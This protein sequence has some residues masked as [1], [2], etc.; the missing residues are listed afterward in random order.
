MI[1]AAPNDE[2][3]SLGPWRPA[4]RAGSSFLRHR[5]F[6]AAH[7]SC[8]LAHRAVMPRVTRPSQG[9]LGALARWMALTVQRSARNLCAMRRWRPAATTPNAGSHWA[10]LLREPDPG[11]AGPRVQGR[12][13]F[14]HGTRCRAR[15]AGAHPSPGLAIVQGHARAAMHAG[16]LRLE[17]AVQRGVES[18]STRRLC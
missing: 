13:A 12:S 17:A 8:L 4:S 7:R 2:A 3:S 18:A 16:R 14:R 5:R 15:D 9:E 6:S 11:R 10:A 1:D